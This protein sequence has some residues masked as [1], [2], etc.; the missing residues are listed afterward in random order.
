MAKQP[1]HKKAK[2]Q[3]IGVKKNSRFSVWFKHHQQVAVD[4]L[5][6]L[7]AE[8]ASSLL[9]WSVIGIA[10]ALPIFLLLLME[11]LQQF[12]SDLDD[13][14]QIS[15]YM[16]LDLS[17]EDLQEISRD[18]TLLAEVENVQLISASQALTDFENVSG[19]GDV[20]QGLDENPLPAVLLVSPAVEGV[21]E[22]EA[23]YLNLESFDGV[24]S[25]Q[26]DMEWIQRLYSILDLAQ[27]MTLILAGLLCIGVVLVVGN[28]VRL[29]IENR[30]AEIV[31]VKLVGGTDAYVA[32][33]FLYTGLWYGVG[34]GLIA[35]VLIL[36][37][38]FFLKGPVSRMAGLYEGNFNL[39]GLSISGILLVLIGS[40]LLGWVGAW[41][42]VLRHL[43]SIEPR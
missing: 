26:L 23:L 12:G 24:D 29:A 19:F 14:T 20:L 30:R 32:R 42:S 13:A 38:Q 37:A 25:A 35:S 17:D 10:L 15:L 40:G 27:R 22:V 7:L 2:Q 28:T 5:D 36:L 11:N 41:L 3:K 8:T 1:E 6:R 16:D 33:P 34:G 21:A 39:L 31:V 18:M 43:K 9:T 4:S